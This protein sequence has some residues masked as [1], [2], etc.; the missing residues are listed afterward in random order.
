MRLLLDTQ[1]FLWF[2]GGSPEVSSTARS[3][4]EG[5]DEKLVSAG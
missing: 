1:T 4:I 3:L 5:P 2:I